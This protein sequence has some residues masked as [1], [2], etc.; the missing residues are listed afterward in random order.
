MPDPV[1]LTSRILTLKAGNAVGVSVSGSTVHMGVDVDALK[2]K[3]NRLLVRSINGIYAAED[4]AFF[5][6]GSDCE[7]WGYVENS[8]AMPMNEEILDE[9]NVIIDGGTASGI[10]IT[11]L[12]PACQTCETVYAI[13]QDL[14]K[15][16]VLVNMIKDVELHDTDSLESH[17]SQLE[18]MC[19][20][21]ATVGCSHP[22]TPFDAYKGL[23]LLQQYITVVHLWNYAVVQNNASFRL[24]ISPE[25]TAG[26]VIQT[27]R[28][29]PNC[30]GSWRIR[31]SIHIEYVQALG[32]DG[33]PK[34]KQALSVYLPPPALRFKPF[35]LEE[36]SDEDADVVTT[37]EDV[38]LDGHTAS[39]QTYPDCTTKD[40]LTGDIPARVGGTY[41]LTVKVL[42]FINFVMY[43]KE[44][45]VISVRGGTINIS[46]TTVGDNVF[47]DFAPASTT[48][49]PLQNPTKNDYLNA[50][51]APTASVPFNNIWSVSVK[52]E[53]GKPDTTTP[54]SGFTWT[55]I[56]RAENVEAVN[57]TPSMGWDSLAGAN[58]DFEPYSWF[59][60][61]ETKLYTCT[62]VREPNNQ[63]IISN[64]TIPV[65]VTPEQ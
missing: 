4:G 57:D 15:L 54:V 6:N 40:V 21:G 37:A 46:G 14:E 47:Y 60:Y 58:S 62:G 64:S 25:D 27:K 18:S 61:A 20:D 28:S 55:E 2:A 51:T 3:M 59:E 53:I 56:N 13:K 22:W 35:H 7:S 44:G 50:K 48:R 26:F 38:A 45:H 43:D 49:I 31:C 16:D 23:Q 34:T 24:E 12:C 19:I 65:D 29:L 10:W 42:P 41:E 17:K 8:H 5:I 63:A 30:D 39:I 52:W 36:S 1:V 9:N 32:D 33:E 11:D